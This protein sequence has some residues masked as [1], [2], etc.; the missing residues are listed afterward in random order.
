[1]KKKSLIIMSRLSLLEKG[2]Q[3]PSCSSSSFLPLHHDTEVVSDGAG[4]DLTFA[5]HA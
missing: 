1:M 5:E 4:V 3:L 2:K